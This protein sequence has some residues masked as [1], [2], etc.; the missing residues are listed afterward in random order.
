MIRAS[1]DCCH[2]C[3]IPDSWWARWDDAVG[4]WITLCDEHWDGPREA[5]CP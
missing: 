1:L 2:V 5:P 3:G 4:G